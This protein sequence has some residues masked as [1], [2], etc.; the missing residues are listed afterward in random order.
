MLVTVLVTYNGKVSAEAPPLTSDLS[1]LK[2][3]PVMLNLPVPSV[4]SWTIEDAT[5]VLIDVHV[6]SVVD[7][8]GR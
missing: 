5:G 1:N 2:I 6:T 3:D 7:P 4:V 8:Q